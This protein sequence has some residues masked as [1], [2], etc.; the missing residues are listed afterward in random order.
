MYSDSSK[1]H[2]YP[3][4]GPPVFYPPDPNGCNYQQYPARPMLPRPLPPQQVI[5]PDPYRPALPRRPPPA[6]GVLPPPPHGILPGAP[7][8][9]PM[10]TILVCRCRM[11]LS[12][13]LVHTVVN[14][15][16]SNGI[17]KPSKLG[18]CIII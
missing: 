14:Y 9:L 4:V 13:Y 8:L 16:R 3:G 6:A 2:H 11:P 5:P 12:T 17:P 18:C 7:P 1:S 10:V 15:M